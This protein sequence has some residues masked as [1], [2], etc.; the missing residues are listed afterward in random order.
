MGFSKVVIFFDDEESGKLGLEALVGISNIKV[1]VRDRPELLQLIADLDVSAG[2]MAAYNSDVSA[3]QMVHAHAVASR[4]LAG[5]WWLAHLDA[6]ELLVVEGEGELSEL[7]R[8]MDERNVGQMTLPTSKEFHLAILR[9][10]TTSR[11]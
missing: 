11:M 7:W 8:W 3:R 4:V 9:M 10:T 2:L 5:P 6:D 1:F